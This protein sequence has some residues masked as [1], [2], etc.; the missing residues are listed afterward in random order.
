MTPLT[1]T[2]I[3]AI[4]S[5]FPDARLNEP[6][7]AHT[8]LRIGGPARLYVALGDADQI[9]QAVRV[10]E[11]AGVPWYVFGGGSNLLVADTGFEGLVIQATLRD[12]R[13]EG[14]SVHAGAGAITAL[15]ARKA[16]DAGLTGF[17]WAI[18]VPGT[19][20][21]AVYGNAGCYG[22]EMK[23]VITAVDAYDIAQKKRVTYTNAEC[24]F[25]Y[26]ESRFKK[27][28]HLI[29]G[30]TIKLAPGDKNTANARMKEIVDTRK[31]KQPLDASSAGC[32]FKNFEFTNEADIAKL[33]SVTDVPEAMVRAK[34][35]PAGWLVDQAGLLGTSVG[36]ISV[37]QKHGNFLVQKSGATAADTV[38]LMQNIKKTIQER[39]GIVLQEEVQLLGF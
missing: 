31:E 35:I 6:M 12:L 22:G 36:N 29:F 16:A 7:S 10:A 21:G 2:Q 38:A 5:V 17:E 8:N 34:R 39:F 24:Q 33:Q 13:T 19:M 15:V 11:E 27:E 1:P 9:V 30:C 4:T 32:A 23:D 3:A 14:E 28:R 20:G 25:G 26:R 18:G 37:S